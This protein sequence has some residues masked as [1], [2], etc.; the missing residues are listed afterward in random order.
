MLIKVIAENFKSFSNSTEL[1]MISSTKIQKG[2]DHRVKI[3]GTNILKYAVIYGANA[4]GK[5]NLIDFFWLLKNTLNDSIPLVATKWFCKCK[6]E[7]INKNSTFEIQFTIDNKF[8]AYGFTAILNQRRIT[9]EWLYE[10][11][12]NGNAKCLFER[13]EG[14]KIPRLGEEI[15]LDKAD[16]ARFK[17]YVDDFEGNES[18][19]FLSE[20]NRNKKYTN[21]SKLIFFQ[22]TYN[23]L[24]RNIVIVKPNTSF[25]NFQ[26][27]NDE[28]SLELINN[29]IKTFDTGIEKVKIVE[30]DFEEFKKA[31]PDEVFELVV[32]DIRNKM[33]H[34]IPSVS[35]RLTMRT[36][37]NFFTVSLGEDEP[38]VYT[39]RLNHGKSFYDFTFD[40][41]S[42]GTRRIFDLLDMLLNKNDD[43]IY[44]VDELERSL[45]PKLTEHF[46]ELFMKF[47]KDHK[48][49]L[50]FTTHEASIMEQKLFR[51]DEIWFIERDGQN[52]SNVYSL[53]KFKERYDKTLSKA[54]LEGRYGAVP[55]FSSF[56]IMEE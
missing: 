30:T 34:K 38:K 49:Q 31:L 35:A 43:I 19:L 10:L 25:N 46:L 50:L 52:T 16:E 4:A 47:H 26:Y 11:Y 5:S 42:D 36:E 6:E 44:V 55:V 17:T 56:D 9:S 13:N 12:Q 22:E 14:E 7:N 39:L 33:A 23:W 27:Y 28:T 15:K 40:E 41:E 51:R 29:L 32:K 54:Y 53:D 2:I 20:M 3:K 21:D 24:S 48:T 8:Y 1:T 37:D 45:H 18:I